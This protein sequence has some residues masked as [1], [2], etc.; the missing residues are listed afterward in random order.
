M[1]LDWLFNFPEM[2]GSL[3]IDFVKLIRKQGMVMSSKSAAGHGMCLLDAFVF[4][5]S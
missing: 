3:R 2:E 4:L 1:N 5:K